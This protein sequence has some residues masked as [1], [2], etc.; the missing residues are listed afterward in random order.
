LKL[1]Q[2]FERKRQKYQPIYVKK[3]FNTVAEWLSL[4]V[5]IAFLMELQHK[6][7]FVADFLPLCNVFFFWP[8]NTSYNIVE[9]L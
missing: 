3:R 1:S 8:S 7:Q 6:I 4:T 5:G 9:A 2:I